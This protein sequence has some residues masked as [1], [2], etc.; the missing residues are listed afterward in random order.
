MISKNVL[1]K[2]CVDG[3]FITSN[4]QRK[5]YK[6]YKN[7]SEI[8]VSFRGDIIWLYPYKNEFLSACL[9]I[10]IKNKKEYKYIE[11]IIKIN[12]D[13][14]TLKSKPFSEIS[15]ITNSNK[16][17]SPYLKLSVF[18]RE[19]NFSNV[20]MLN[21]EFDKIKALLVIDFIYKKIYN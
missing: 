1:V 11:K 21:V 4:K 10:K 3:N 14:I 8:F 7:S 19:T 12:N 5:K 9:K 20:L 6:T 15:G 13:I 2:Y 17:N 16:N 18:P